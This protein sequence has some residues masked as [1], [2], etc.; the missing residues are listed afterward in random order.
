MPLLL[1]VTHFPQEFVIKIFSLSTMDL[2]NPIETCLPGDF[3]SQMSPD[4]CLLGYQGASFLFGIFDLTPEVEGTGE[5]KVKR[6]HGPQ[7]PLCLVKVLQKHPWWL[8]TVKPTGNL[9]GKLHLSHRRQA[10][11]SFKYKPHL[12]LTVQRQTIM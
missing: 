11:L 4:E 9:C 2:H 5:L 3:L 1:V 12:L 10:A 7:A 6:G 8:R